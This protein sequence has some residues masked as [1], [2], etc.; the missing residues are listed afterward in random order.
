MFIN[1]TI[2]HSSEIKLVV[3]LLGFGKS[4]MKKASFWYFA[5]SQ[6]VT[7]SYNSYGSFFSM[8]NIAITNSFCYAQ[9]SYKSCL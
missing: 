9:I 4:W 3:N 7:I 2:F 6:L 5:I 8:R 1:I